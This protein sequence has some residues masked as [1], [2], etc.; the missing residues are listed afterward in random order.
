VSTAEAPVFILGFPRSGTTLLGQILA[1]N[2]EVALL[3]ERSLLDEAIAEF[4]D[5][6][7]GMIRLAG[8]SAQDLEPFRADF[9]ARAA[10][11]ATGNGRRIVDQTALNAVNLPLI[12]RLFPEAPVVFAIRD[13][14]DVVFS[15]FRRQFA[16]S[17]FTL[18]F[19]TLESTARFYDG[20]MR[21]TDLCRARMSLKLHEIRHEDVVADFDAQIGRLCAFTGIAWSD[22][23]RDF[24]RGAEDRTV[25]TRSAAQIRRGLSSD[26]VGAWKRYRDELAPVLP[27]LEPWIAR[28]GYE[29]G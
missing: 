6:P 20:T 28:F 26:G 8:M 12:G 19:R 25:A 24:H 11:F 16:P 22:A 18:E 2:P 23:M 21:L 1:V 4:V 14:R 17:R 3:E 13:P 15:C 29:A 5:T 9:E 10:G 7:D 27:I